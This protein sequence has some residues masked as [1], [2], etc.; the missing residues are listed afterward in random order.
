MAILAKQ[1]ALAAALLSGKSI[2][3]AAIAAGVTERTAYRWTKD[4]VFL[5]ELAKLRREAIRASLDF[6]TAAA[7]AAAGEIVITMRNP[8]VPPAVRLRAACEVLDRLTAWVELE[9]LDSRI[10]TLEAAARQGGNHDTSTH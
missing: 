4:P 5:A 9:D 6:L 1:D 2:P 3:Q 10:A 8:D 7:R